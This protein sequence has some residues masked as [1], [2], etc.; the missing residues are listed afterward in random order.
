MLALTF[1]ITAEASGPATRG[2]VTVCYPLTVLN[3]IREAIRQARWAGAETH[4][5]A[6]EAMASVIEAAPVEAV[7]KTGSTKVRAADMVGL[8][9]GD[10]ITL[11]HPAD[12]PFVVEVEG[13]EIL[14]CDIG[15]TGPYLAAR[16]RR[17]IK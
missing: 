5:T 7:V 14:E 11:D 17:W 6:T 16:V 13:A 10:V 1:S 8:A 9:P 4:H 2:I 3:P 15:H 12:E